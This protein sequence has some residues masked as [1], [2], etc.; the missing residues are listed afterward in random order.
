MHNV[1]ILRVSSGLAIACL[2]LVTACSKDGN[3][4]KATNLAPQIDCNSIDVVPVTGTSMNI[5]CAVTD[6]E[7]SSDAVT[8]SWTLLNG[9]EGVNGI[10]L[11]QTSSVAYTPML[12]GHYTLQLSANDGAAVSLANVSFDVAEAEATSQGLLKI[13]PLGDSITQGNQYTLSYRHSLWKKLLDSG[14]EF[15]LVGG[16]TENK[17]GSPKFPDYQGVVFDRDHQGH[18]GYTADEILTLLPNALLKYDA[19]VVLIHLGTNDIFKRQSTDSTI[20]E[21]EKIVRV[22]RLDNPAI[23]IFLAEPIPVNG[24]PAEIKQLG[25]AIRDLAP[26][27]H[28]HRSPVILVNQAA[29]FSVSKDTYDGIHPNA[30]GEEKLASKWFEAIQI[31]SHQLTKSAK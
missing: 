16:L 5:Q 30:T 24:Y 29:G 12:A 11:P 9:P 18:W 10:H 7:Q 14:I 4:D 21:L 1:L 27:L 6:D 20:D 2:L 28:Q 17:K 25:A 8:V 22:L 3:R 15:D 13:L 26:R 31:Y 19:D 23:T